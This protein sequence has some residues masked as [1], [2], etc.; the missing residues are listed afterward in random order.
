MKQSV[1]RIFQ[2]KQQKT[3]KPAKAFPLQLYS[4]DIHHNRQSRH[5][6]PTFTN[7]TISVYQVYVILSNNHSERSFNEFNQGFKHQAASFH[8][9]VRFIWIVQFKKQIACP[10]KGQA[11]ICLSLI[12][13]YRR[14]YREHQD[15]RSRLCYFHKRCPVS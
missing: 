9:L 15:S 11:V 7:I 5:Q 8:R 3:G 2:R 1:R 14:F 4:V 13:F 6:K 12:Y 10:G